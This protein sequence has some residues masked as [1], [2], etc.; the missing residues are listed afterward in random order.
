MCAR[1]TDQTVQFSG[2]AALKL[3]K[4]DY[5]QRLYQDNVL[6]FKPAK[7]AKGGEG[8]ITVLVILYY[9]F[10]TFKRLLPPCQ[11]IALL[12]KQPSQFFH[13]YKNSCNSAPFCLFLATLDCQVSVLAPLV[14]AEPRNATMHFRKRIEF[15]ILV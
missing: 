12:C 7:Q 14:R 2:K 6:P 10:I 11:Q 5:I 3:S 13:L 15:V 8:P 9:I 4:T 1:S